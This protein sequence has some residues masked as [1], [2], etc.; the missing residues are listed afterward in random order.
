[1]DVG[2]MARVSRGFAQYATQAKNTANSKSNAQ[3][4]TAAQAQM[5]KVGDAFELSI[6]DAAK[7]AQQAPKQSAEEFSVEDAGAKETKGLS[8]EQVDALK[9]D[10]QTQEQTM[11]NVMIQALT[12]SNNKLQSWLDDGIGILNFNGVQIDAARFGLPEV[13]TNA[14]D[15]AKAIA[16][17]GAWSVDAVSSRIFDLASAIA[18][19]DP[20]KLS[21][22]RAA[23]EEGFKQAG[24]TWKDATGQSNLPDISNQTYNEIMSR[25]DKRAGELSGTLG[26]AGAS[27]SE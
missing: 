19:D 23:V 27:L 4:T 26:T 3:N 6:S 1:M 21:Q 11:L 17:G 16:P 14:E 10:L 5:E 20:E 12:E 22:M 25:F 15:A 8:A 18:G 7:Q 2:S 13:A 9:S 24:M